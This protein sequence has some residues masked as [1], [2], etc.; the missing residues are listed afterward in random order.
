MTTGATPSINVE[1]RRGQG[2]GPPETFNLVGEVK[3]W[4]GPSG[5]ANVST[6]A[7]H[8]QS[9]AVEKIMGLPDEGQFTAT[10]NYLAS[11]AEQQALISDRIG[12]ILRNFQVVLPAPASQTIS[13]AAYVIG[14]ELAG[15]DPASG[16][17]IDANLTLEISGPLTYT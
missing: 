11:N 9:T 2:D 4:S 12:R 8:Q 10:M 7:T 3:D 5:S 13:F 16:D 6:A 17:P 15:A 14:F 1:L